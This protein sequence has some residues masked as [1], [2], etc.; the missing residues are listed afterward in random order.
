MNVTIPLSSYLFFLFLFS[1]HGNAPPQYYACDPQGFNGKCCMVIFFIIGAHKM[2]VLEVYHSLFYYVP[3][4][5]AQNALVV[6][7][8]VC[9]WG[10]FVDSTNFLARMWPRAS[11]PGERLW[12]PQNINNAGEASPRLHMQRCR[13]MT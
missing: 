6:G 7:G 5:A 9:M 4:T 1:S 10:E 3:G 2:P 11:A 12:S 8:E 13:M